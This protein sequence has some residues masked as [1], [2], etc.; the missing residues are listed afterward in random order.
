MNCPICRRGVMEM[1]GYIPIQNGPLEVVMSFTVPKGVPAI[2][3][4]ICS[5]D[6]C[7]NLDLGAAPES[8][9]L[10]K[11]IIRDKVHGLPYLA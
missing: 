6:H 8:L 1:I 9:T 4:R 2:Q 11:R 5:L 3:I 7:G 10:A